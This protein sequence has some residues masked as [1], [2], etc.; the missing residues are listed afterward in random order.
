MRRTNRFTAWALAAAGVCA[1][2][3]PAQAFYWQGWPKTPDSTIA[4]TIIPPGQDIPGTPVAEP[5][6]PGGEPKWPTP[7]EEYPPPPP[8][9]VPE[10]ATGVVGLIGLGVLAARKWRKR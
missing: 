2:A 5:T 10:P 1:A 3:T 8:G 9:P 7:P 6:F 4:R